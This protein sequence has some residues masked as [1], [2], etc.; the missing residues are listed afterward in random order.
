MLTLAKIRG[1]KS[2]LAL[3]DV[4]EIMRVGKVNRILLDNFNP[5]KLKVAVDIINGSFE[6]EASGK[7][8]K[9]NVLAYAQTGV[10]FISVGYITH[11]IKSLDMS[12]KAI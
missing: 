1:R 11:H 4:A 10:K 7:I 3:E 12:L 8:N 6:T 9:D 5:D 2:R